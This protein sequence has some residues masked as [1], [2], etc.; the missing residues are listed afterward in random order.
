MILG[1]DPE[2]LRRIALELE[3][4]ADS[5]DKAILAITAQVENTWWQ[6]GDADAFRQE[7]QALHVERLRELRNRLRVSAVEC[8]R[9][10]GDQARASG[11]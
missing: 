6:G 2:Q 8:R 9:H 4:E 11:S 10:S 1:S 5:L 3:V 7:W